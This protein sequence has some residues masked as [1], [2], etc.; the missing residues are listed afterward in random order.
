MSEVQSTDPLY[1]ASDSAISL[2][3][4]GELIHYENFMNWSRTQR[5]DIS[6]SLAS[7][8]GQ[9]VGVSVP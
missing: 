1:T 4:L 3:W 8:P 9:L 6:A 5:V 7:M 2:E